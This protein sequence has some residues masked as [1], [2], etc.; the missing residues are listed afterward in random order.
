MK[1]AVVAVLALLGCGA[2]L[3]KNARPGPTSVVIEHYSV[4]VPAGY[5][6]AEVG[7]KEDFDL[8]LIISVRSPRKRLGLYIGNHPSFPAYKWGRRAR[9]ETKTDVSLEEFEYDG[10]KMEGLMTFSGLT[11]KTQSHSPFP[12]VHYF[13]NDADAAD[14]K[15]FAEIVRSIRV[16]KP[17]LE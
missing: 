13:T 8:Y 2:T 15:R 10:Q 14:A 17:H 16:T 4:D 6:I 11:Y 3:P 9:E 5:S 7:P 1:A 12:R